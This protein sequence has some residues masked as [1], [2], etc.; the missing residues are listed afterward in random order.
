MGVPRLLSRMAG[1]AIILNPTCG[2]STWGVDIQIPRRWHNTHSSDRRGSIGS[3]RA[4]ALALSQVNHSITSKSV[5]QSIPRAS[6]SC[7]PPD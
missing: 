7:S 5:D 3:T 4:V 6:W 1:Y 2:K